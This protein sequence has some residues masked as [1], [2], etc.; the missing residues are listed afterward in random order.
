MFCTLFYDAELTTRNVI[1]DWLTVQRSIILFD[2]QLD[3]QN[4]Y[5]F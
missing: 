4:S 3:A 1:D 2:L 5:L